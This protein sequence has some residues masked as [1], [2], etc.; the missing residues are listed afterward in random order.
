MRTTH[1]HGKRKRRGR[2][3]AWGAHGRN[4]VA[5]PH[6][7]P[8]AR[9]STRFWPWICFC[10]LVNLGGH[11]RRK[12]GKAPPS[13]IWRPV[14]K[15]AHGGNQPRGNHDLPYKGSHLVVCTAV[16]VPAAHSSATLETRVQWSAAYEGAIFYPPHVRSFRRV[17]SLVL[18]SRDFGLPESLVDYAQ[19]IASAQP[20][21]STVASRPARS[22]LD[23]L[24][25]PFV[26]RVAL[27]PRSLTRPSFIVVCAASYRSGCG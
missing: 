15:T 16:L 9:P 13:W 12:V 10:N 8:A 22:V 27:L 3:T 14:R 1:E 17:I 6:V 20:D 4:S 19:S 21:R 25:S 7:P 2:A 18:P 26:L 24:L 23:F 5:Y 11:D